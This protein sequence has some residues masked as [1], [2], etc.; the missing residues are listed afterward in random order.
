M[1]VRIQPSEVHPPH[2]LGGGCRRAPKPWTGARSNRS[3]SRA[4]CATKAFPVPYAIFFGVLCAT[5]LVGALAA[6]WGSLRSAF[7]G[8]GGTRID[9]RDDTPERAALLDEKT[10]LLRAIKDLQYEHQ[11]GKLDQ[12][13]FERL[14]R[15]YRARAKE[16]LELLDRDAR[17]YRARA[18]A[19]L[20]AAIETPRIETPAKASK[21][22]RK[23]S[24]EVSEPEPE[25]GVTEPKPGVTEPKASATEPKSSVTKAAP[26]ESLEAKLVGLSPEKRAQAEAFLAQLAAEP[27]PPASAE[28]EPDE[29]DDEDEESDK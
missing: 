5:C 21:A 11:V 3:R 13:D 18:E 26:N 25:A 7:G 15:A 6:L 28:D 17:P 29:D 2:P 14:D 22:K 20:E 12:A 10:A 9:T 24:A 19:L 27:A 23:K 16:V 4:R 8:E 1:L